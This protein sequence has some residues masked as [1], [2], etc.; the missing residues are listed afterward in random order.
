M[1]FQSQHGPFVAQYS[2]FGPEVL[3]IDHA[4][5]QL[6]LGWI[7]NF[8]FDSKHMRVYISAFKS[9]LKKSLNYINKSMSIQLQGLSNI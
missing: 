7:S 5:S 3:P 2:L 1:T 4:P 6:G 9:F 8:K